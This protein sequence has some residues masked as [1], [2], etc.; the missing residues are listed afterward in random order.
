MLLLKNTIAFGLLL[1][2]AG[3]LGFAADRVFNEVGEID[4][5]YALKSYRRTRCSI[6]ANP[7]SKSQYLI[8]QVWNETG[9]HPFV[10]GIRV[11]SLVNDSGS[12]DVSNQ[13][14]GLDLTLRGIEIEARTYR[15]FYVWEGVSP[16]GV[17]LRLRNPNQKELL[18]WPL[19]YSLPENFFELSVVENGKTTSVAHLFS[20]CYDSVLSKHLDVLSSAHPQLHELY[21]NS[22]KYDPY[23]VEQ[24]KK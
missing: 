8:E 9:K 24:S 1:S 18:R 10:E 15:P 5:A 7:N 22:R 6:Y 23:S 4:N 16:S 12:V 13:I 17:E 2:L 3:N 11:S 20:P 19:T 21:K 14:V